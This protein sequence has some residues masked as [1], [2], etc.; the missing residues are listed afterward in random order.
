M[1]QVHFLS[2]IICSDS[3]HTSPL[4]GYLFL[5]SHEV[6]AVVVSLEKL[7]IKMKFNRLLGSVD[8]TFLPPQ[9]SFLLKIIQDYKGFPNSIVL[10]PLK[11]MLRFDVALTL[12]QGD[13]SFNNHSESQQMKAFILKRWIRSLHPK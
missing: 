9:K 1:K 5:I 2:G 11:T 7:L 8:L 6:I 4:I 3:K 10:F 12:L 13:A